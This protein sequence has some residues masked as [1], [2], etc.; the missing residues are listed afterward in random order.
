MARVSVVWL[1]GL[2]CVAVASAQESPG[3]PTPRFRSAADVVT[4]QAAVR[5]DRGR[6]LQGLTAADFEVR[7]NGE[8]RPILTL[9][10]DL[11]SPVSLAVLVD[12]SG[13]MVMGPK[14]EMARHALNSVLSQLRPGEDEAAVFTF[15]AELHERRPFSSDPETLKGALDDFTPFG[16]TSL[17][18]ATAAAARRLSERSASHK[19]IVVLTDGLDTSSTLTAPQVSGLA[20]SIAVPVYVVATVPSIDQRSMLETLDRSGQSDAADLRDLTEWTGGQLVFASTLTETASVA[21]GLVNEL[22]LQYVLAIE[23]VNTPEWRR[24]DVRVK[25]RS[26]VVRA[27]NGYYGG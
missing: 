9:R 20:S 18:D 4:I 3:I 11:R 19:A 16:S 27:R 5:T 21:S 23:A 24:L 26:T 17:Y 25:R 2:S 22:R 1:L 10:S 7:D 12:M 13:S 6:P 15:D 14:M 8:L